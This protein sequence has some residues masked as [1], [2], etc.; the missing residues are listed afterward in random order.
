MD[1]D[2]AV[3]LS[4]VSSEVVNGDFNLLTW[5]DDTRLRRKTQ[6]LSV[7]FS[8]E[9]EVA[10]LLTDVAD[11]E[12]LRLHGM[13]GADAAKVDERIEHELRC[14][15]PRVQWNGNLTFL[16]ANGQSV[17]VVLDLLAGKLY[18]D[19][20]LHSGCDALL[21]VDES[22]CIGLRRTEANTLD[23]VADVVDRE[24]NH[25]H[26]TRLNI[27][28]LTYRGSHCD[29]LDGGDRTHSGQ[30]VL[31]GRRLGGGLAVVSRTRCCCCHDS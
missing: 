14:W 16:G 21:S 12:L 27:A 8:D 10:V 11:T 15:E 13:L 25:E 6:A 19:Y 7:G 5:M 26:H 30:C 18:F 2:D 24:G 29:G 28:E 1:V 22:E 17:V 23:A 31:L 3:E 9:L 20:L 4:T